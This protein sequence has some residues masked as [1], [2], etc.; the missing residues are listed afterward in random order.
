MFAFS[1]I[2]YTPTT[3]ILKLKSQIDKLVKNVPKQE[4][5]AHIE[6]F[7]ASGQI[8]KITIEEAQKI[9]SSLTPGQVA[10]AFQTI[11]ENR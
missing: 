4:L 5:D 7:R 6:R 3:P 10:E 11:R 8:P 9:L 2:D 1:D